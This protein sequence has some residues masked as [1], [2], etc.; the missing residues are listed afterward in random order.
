MLPLLILVLASGIFAYLRATR[1]QKPVAAI[2]ER[3]WRVGV[4]PARLQLLAPQLAL[5]GKVENPN[6][7]RIMAA[8]PAQV[9]EVAV[10]DGQHVLPGALL[11]SLDDRDFLPALHQAEALEA[12]LV[13]LI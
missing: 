13:A 12:E 6:L 7:L 9:A 4:E 10:R 3:V 11:V 5:Y 8:G 1:P 2:E